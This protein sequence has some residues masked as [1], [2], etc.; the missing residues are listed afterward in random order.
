MSR[1]FWAIFITCLSALA[2]DLAQSEIN[3][4]KRDLAFGETRRI[5]VLG[6]DRWIAINHTSAVINVQVHEDAISV[7]AIANGGL[8]L[9]EIEPVGG[10]SRFISF[11]IAPKVPPFGDPFRYEIKTAKDS[12]PI[13]SEPPRGKA[14]FTNG[15]IVYSGDPSGVFYAV[16]A[17]EGGDLKKKTIAPT[18]RGLVALDSYLEISAGDRGFLPFDAPK[19]IQP[20]VAAD[21]A[22]ITAEISPRG[23]AYKAGETAGEDKLIFV[24]FAGAEPITLP[25]RVRP[26]NGALFSPRAAK[27][28]LPFARTFLGAR[29][30]VRADSQGVT[31]EIAPPRGAKCAVKTPAQA[32]ITSLESGG[33][34]VKYKNAL[35]TITQNCAIS[36]ENSGNSFGI[37]RVE[38]AAIDAGGLVKAITAN[39][40]LIARENEIAVTSGG[41]GFASIPRGE[42]RLTHSGFT[43][44]A[45]MGGDAFTPFGWVW[46]AD[47]N[48]ELKRVFD[49]REARLEGDFESGEIVMFLEGEKYLARPIKPRSEKIFLSAGWNAL[50]SAGAFAASELGALKIIEPSPKDPSGWLQF[51]A[52]MPAKLNALSMLASG[53]RYFVFFEKD[54]AVEVSALPFASVWLKGDRYACAKAGESAPL[55][56]PD[57]CSIYAGGEEKKSYKEGEFYELKC[58]EK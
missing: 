8:G 48:G 39:A 31:I 19:N 18:E 41:L 32:Q 38:T 37:A 14:T 42:A 13:L 30:S 12:E 16:F 33:F 51:D 47:D 24:P 6:A 1:F 55:T 26:Q 20:I 5:R 40:V 53:G 9:V 50:C 29:E 58:D 45:I 28:R 43:A 36:G 21:S 4:E 52:R 34:T 11:A 15:A 25:I 27:L 57:G 2:A 7:S 35:L 56:M 22:L 3:Y 17:G 23:I 46:G 44:R 10:K 49:A 54:S